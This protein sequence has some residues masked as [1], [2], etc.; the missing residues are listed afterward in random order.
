MNYE[1]AQREGLVTHLLVICYIT[2]LH[3]EGRKTGVH[4]SELVESVASLGPVNYQQRSQGPALRAKY[5]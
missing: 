5:E 1:L 3:N 2:L 4:T